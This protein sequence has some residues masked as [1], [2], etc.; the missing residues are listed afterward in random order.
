MSVI[1]L[2]LFWGLGREK[3]E[4]GKSFMIILNAS[5]V[6]ARPINKLKDRKA[7]KEGIERKDAMIASLF[8]F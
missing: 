7:K 5:A 1:G 3:D 6:D 2:G 8:I 4:G